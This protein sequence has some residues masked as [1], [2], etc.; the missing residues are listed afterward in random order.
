MACTAQPPSTVG[1]P[2]PVVD[3]DIANLNLLWLLNARAL[4]QS[5]AEKAAVLYGLD[6]ELIEAL[7]EA[8]FAALRGL[9]DSG[10]LLFRPRFHRRF[11]Q[12]HL[13]CAHAAA[14]AA[15]RLQSVLLAA[16]ELSAP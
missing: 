5:D 2:E 1:P 10:V 9:A 11:L 13:A 14:A 7:R 12:E 8:P 6:R 3:A 16:E 15:F 4:A